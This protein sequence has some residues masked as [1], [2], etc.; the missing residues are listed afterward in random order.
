MASIFSAGNEPNPGGNRDSST[1]GNG[2]PRSFWKHPKRNYKSKLSQ[3][4]TALPDVCPPK[5]LIFFLSQRAQCAHSSGSKANTDLAD[6]FK[7]GD[8]HGVGQIQAPRFRTD[9]DPQ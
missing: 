6:P 3:K 9:R 4:E 7:K 1:R 2:Q 5:R 8:G